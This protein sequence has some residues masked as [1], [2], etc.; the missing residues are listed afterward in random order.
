MRSG[1]KYQQWHVLQTMQMVNFA[2]SFSYISF[3][4][5]LCHMFL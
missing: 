5:I 1:V 2:I 3:S 4:L